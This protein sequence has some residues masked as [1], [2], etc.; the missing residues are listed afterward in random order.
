MQIFSH[1]PRQWKQTVIP[2]EEIE[3]FI[4]LREAYDI[5]PV[6][7]HASYLINLAS[8]S[9]EVLGKSIDLLSYELQCADALGVEYVVLHTGSARGD[10]ENEARKRAVGSLARAVSGG[11][12]RTSI[13]LENTAGERGDI[14]SSVRALAV[15]IDACHCGGIGGICIDTCH[16]FASGYR[17]TSPAGLEKLFAEIDTYIGLKNLRLI[18]F[19]DSKKPFNSGVDRHEHIGEGYIGLNGFRNFLSD[20]RIARVPLILETPKRTDEDDRRNMRTV[21]K[22]LSG[23][24][25]N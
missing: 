7:I 16:A 4:S 11:K 19:N 22:M 20:K 25:R 9:R 1:N 23:R 5:R 21:Y 14:T 18:H 6:Y 3:R 13:L 17:L 8:R 24:V 12:Y 15:I 10:D 2:K